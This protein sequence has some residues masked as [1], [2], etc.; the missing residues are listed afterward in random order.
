LALWLGWLWGGGFRWKQPPLLSPILTPASGQLNPISGRK[1][2]LRLALA[3][4]G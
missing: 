2:R 3:G 4:I 1:L